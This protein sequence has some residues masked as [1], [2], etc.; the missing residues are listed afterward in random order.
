MQDVGGSNTVVMGPR[1]YCA[2]LLLSVM[3][4]VVTVADD[5]M[6]GWVEEG[7]LRQ[8]MPYERSYETVK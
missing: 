8:A 3:Y 7:A 6:S 5:I 1:L 4:T 2:I